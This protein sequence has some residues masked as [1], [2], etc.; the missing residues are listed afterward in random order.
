[1]AIKLIH[2]T[3]EY[4]VS[5]HARK[6]VN[7]LCPDA[8]QTLGLE[9]VEGDVKTVDEAVTALKIAIGALRTVGL[10]GG[11]KTVWLR[12]VSIFKDGVISRNEKVKGLLAQLAE[13]IKKGLPDGHHLIVS[14]PGVDRRSAFYKTCAASAEVEAYDLPEQAYLKEPIIRER[15]IDVLDHLPVGEAFD[16]VER[17]SIE[18]TTRMLA[19]LFDFPFEQRSKLTH[20]SD[21]STAIPG[22]GLIES[23]EERQQILLGCLE[24]FTE[25]W[26]QRVN[27]PLSNDL[28]SMLA[29]GESTRNMSPLEYL[30]NLILLIV[31]GNDTTRNTMSAS[32]L[33]L[34]QNPEQMALLRQN[35]LRFE[36]GLIP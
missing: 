6:A 13:D 36:R 7:A 29:H 25:L 23:E 1:M 34:H 19:T 4:L 20:W 14:A 3:D 32:V 33:A 26:N 5:H 35:A 28:V 24:E 12:D 10:F 17:V 16:W 11:Q 31:G 27:A 9:T 30:G 21:V 2:G 18:L 15:T 22:M 8:E